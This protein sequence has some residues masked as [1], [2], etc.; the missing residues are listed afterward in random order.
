[1]FNLELS[2]DKLLHGVGSSGA[3]V[4]GA[5]VGA[6]VLGHE[7]EG[8]VAADLELLAQIPVLVAVDI[9]DGDVLGAA[10]QVGRKLLVGDLKPLAVAAP[11]G[12]ERYVHEIKDV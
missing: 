9:G 5:V 7:E 3:V 10:G 11:G 2:L 12:W 8:R 6:S 4:L 1:M